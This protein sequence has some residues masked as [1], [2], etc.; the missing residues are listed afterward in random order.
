[1]FS[2]L[3]YKNAFEVNYQRRLDI[4]YAYFGV[5][6]NLDV[7]PYLNMLSQNAENETIRK[8]IIN[9]FCIEVVNNINYSLN[10]KKTNVL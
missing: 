3:Y 2:T 1:L 8:N 7:T 4:L 5:E 10:M 6:N 9:Q